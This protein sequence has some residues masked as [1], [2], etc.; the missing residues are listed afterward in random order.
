MVEISPWNS[1]ASQPHGGQDCGR[2]LGGG[3]D[4][5]F[6]PVRAGPGKL[7]LPPAM[8]GRWTVGKVF[9]VQFSALNMACVHEGMG[10]G[11]VKLRQAPGLALLNDSAYVLL[12][13]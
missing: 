2:M 7:S 4:F 12:M 6:P 1:D 3:R 5:H 8:A 9:S 10:D 13:G 11:A